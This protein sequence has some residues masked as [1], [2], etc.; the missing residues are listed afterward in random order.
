MTNETVNPAAAPASFGQVLRNRKFLAFWVALL[1]SSFGDWL[2]FFTLLSVLVFRLN[3]SASAYSLLLLSIFAPLVILGPLAGVFVDGWDLKRTMVAT[4]LIRAVLAAGLAFAPSVPALYLLIGLLSAV[5]CFFTPAQ[6]VAIPLV[7]SKEELL[8]ANTLNSQAI[9]LNRMIAPVA[10]GA[11]VAFIG[12]KICFFID[13]ASFLFSATVIWNVV[14]HR[15]AR[16][17]SR[18]RN[19]LREFAAGARFILQHPVGKFVIVVLL[20]ATF[21]VGLSDGVLAVYVRDI[22]AAGST[23][24]GVL[25]TFI[26]VGTLIGA[27]AVGRFGGATPRPYIVL[28]GFFMLA[29]GVTLLA[30]VRSPAVAMLAALCLGGGSAMVL[31]AAQTLMTEETPLEILGRVSSSAMSMIAISQLGAFA[32]SGA[33]SSRFGIVNLYYGVALALLISGIAGFLYVH[34]QRLH[35]RK[36]GSAS[37]AADSSEIRPLD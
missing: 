26:G 13:A 12:G 16:T 33:L 11:L 25:A 23:T 24:F 2:A 3:G 8:V 10:A 4:D 27:F 15:T 21:T 22:L 29:A 35:L 19:L 14:F 30:L 28:G 6:T 36:E 17:E 37:A 5:S 31:V 7:V 1:V 9:Q 32:A 34:F 20:V 18:V